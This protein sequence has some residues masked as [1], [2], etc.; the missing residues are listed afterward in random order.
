MTSKP[1]TYDYDCEI[2]PLGVARMCFKAHD[3]T[4]A[5]IIIDIGK[6]AF[7]IDAIHDQYEGQTAEIVAQ[8]ME[9]IRQFGGPEVSVGQAEAFARHVLLASKAMEKKMPLLPRE[10]SE[11]PSE[12]NTFSPQFTEQAP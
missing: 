11:E 2:E 9:A 7:L 5:E 4:A 3:G 12:E 1:V 8:Y 6:A 10:P